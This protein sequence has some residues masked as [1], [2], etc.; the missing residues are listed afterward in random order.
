MEE[1]KELNHALIRWRGPSTDRNM[2]ETH[3]QGLGLL[4]FP[5]D[6]LGIFAAQIDDGGDAEFLEFGQALRFRLRAAI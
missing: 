5:D 1:G 4:A 6:S 2:H 3:A